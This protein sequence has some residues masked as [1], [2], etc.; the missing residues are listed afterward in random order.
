MYRPV[1][2]ILYPKAAPAQM[3]RKQGNGQTKEGGGKGNLHFF[4]DFELL[5]WGDAMTL[6]P[7]GL[8]D[9]GDR[10]TIIAGDFVERLARGDV[11]H[12]PLE[13][14][15]RRRNDGRGGAGELLVDGVQRG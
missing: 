5:S 3:Q 11:V 6:E 15:F 9:G 7:V 8:L 14:G 12:D 2:G 13:R 10:D 1:A 4:W